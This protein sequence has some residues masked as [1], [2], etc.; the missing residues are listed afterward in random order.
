LPN[1]TLGVMA[2]YLEGGKLEELAYFRKLSTAGKK[3]GLN[4]IVF[5]PEDVN[6][7]TKQILAWLYDD[8]SGS[9]IRKRVRFPD[10]IYDRCRY[11]RSFRFQLLRKFRTDYPNLLYMSRP[12]LHKWGIHQVLYKSKSIRYYL[13]ETVHYQSHAGL[14]RMLE[15]HGLL[16]VKPIDGTGGRGILR[17]EKQEPGTFLIQGRERS[18]R[19][20]T[21]FTVSGSQLGTRL[22]KWDLV[23]R[24]LIQ[25]GIQLKLPDG[26]VH[27]Y[28]LLIQ[29]NGSGQWEVTGSAGRIGAKRSITSNLHG[30]GSAVSTP[31]LLRMRFTSELR[32]RE[33]EEDMERLA[34]LVVKHL[35]KQFGSMCELALD[36]AVDGSGRVWLL[37]INPKPAREVFSRVGESETY[38][39]AVLRPL[40]YALFLYRQKT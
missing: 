40:E 25:Q 7:E 35:E 37:E 3:L 34:Y 1:P 14:L 18:R 29:K 20:I 26:R 2:L 19:I 16:Y 4:V 11:Q 32:I 12:L 27:D 33:I 38:R 22:A 21:P 17:I 39:K 31:R 13:P 23:R 24:Y 36:I 30:G 5:T 9:W 6:D 8:A 15:K 28:R 10:I